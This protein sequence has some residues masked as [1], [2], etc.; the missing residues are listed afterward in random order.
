M[1][2]IASQKVDVNM[3]VIPWG[4]QLRQPQRPRL[5]PVPLRFA[6]R[7]AQRM[8]FAAASIADVCVQVAMWDVKLPWSHP[9]KPPVLKVAKH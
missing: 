9:P 2:T 3:R 5:H 7:S 4:F 6:R 8:G 1:A